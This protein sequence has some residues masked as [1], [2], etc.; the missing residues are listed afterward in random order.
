MAH[1]LNTVDGKVSMVYNAKEGSPWHNLGQSVDGAFTSKEALEKANLGFTVEKRPLFTTWRDSHI[2]V[3]NN[4][5][6]VRTDTEKVLG[7]VGKG[8]TIVQNVEAFDFFDSIIGEGV[9]AYETAGAL[10]DGERVWISA[11]MPKDIIVKGIDVINQ[12]LLLSLSHDGSSTVQCDFTPVRVVCQN[13]LSQ[14]LSS[15]QCRIS[16]RHTKTVQEKLAQAHKLLG[17][18]A[19]QTE[20]A[21]IEYNKL[22]N[23]DVKSEVNVTSY[24]DLVFGKIEDSD[25]KKRFNIRED[26]KRLFVAGKGNDGKSL[27]SLYNAVTEYTDHE[28]TV[29]ENTNIA[30]AAI[31][32]SAVG[33][34][35]KAY[36]AALQTME[37]IALAV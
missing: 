7:V 19:K 23:T 32:G 29:K 13:T 28:R 2:E 17:L 37:A 24:L 33:I 5:A 18:V 8:Y 22:A 12:Y 26:V 27:W 11:K 10:G 3:P 1:N 16:L 36:T 4:F 31:F 9:A 21:S 25:T 20:A 14:A 35:A 34:K 15:M 30:E 6:N